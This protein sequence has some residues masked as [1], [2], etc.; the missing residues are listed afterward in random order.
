MRKKLPV[1]LGGIVIFFLF[2]FFS[3]LVHKDF[4]T[5]FDF[6][7]TVRLQ[8]NIPRRWD[9]FF[10]LLSVIGRFETVT[11]FLF[12]LLAIYTFIKRKFLALLAFVPFVGLHLIELYGKIFVD[13]PPPPHFL[14]RTHSP[15]DFPQFYVR[16]E[17]SYPSGHSA[18]ALFVTAVIGIFLLSSKRLQP[19]QKMCIMV[20]VFSYDLLMLTSRVYLGEHWSSDVIGGSLLGLAMGMLSVLVL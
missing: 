10:S 7:S 18:R 19:W 15:V 20:G 17:F 9:E 5:D 14:L 11:I 12:V 1:F 6:D 2:I 16:S 8:D 4:F 13:H 3:F